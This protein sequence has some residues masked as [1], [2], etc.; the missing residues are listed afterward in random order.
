MTP[1][2]LDALGDDDWAAMRR[3]MDREIRDANARASRASAKMGA[4]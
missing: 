3:Y 4:R 2:E 1:A